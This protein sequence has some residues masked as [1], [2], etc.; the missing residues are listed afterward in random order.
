[1]VKCDGLSREGVWFLKK[2]CYSPG[3]FFVFFFMTAAYACVL[4]A[5]ESSHKETVLSSTHNI[6]LGED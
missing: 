5:R 1:M 3:F 2:N 6:C 4:G